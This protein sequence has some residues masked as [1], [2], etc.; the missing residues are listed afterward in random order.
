MENI[1][2]AIQSKFKDNRTKA[3]VNLI[4]TAGW[5]SAKQNAFFSEF[6][7]SP[8]Q[9]N[10]LRILR[11]ANEA[12][13]M[14][15]IKSRMIER[16]PNATRL[17]DKLCAKELLQRYPSE[18]DR[19]VVYAEISPQGQELLNNISKSPHQNWMKN[20]SEDE[21]ELLSQLLDKIRY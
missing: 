2:D 10:I 8:Q 15:T 21:A 20:I 18:Q 4:Y 17:V 1:S 19:R 9:Y 12:L 7:I 3:L 5:L 14:Q 6:G 11:G 13:T 16:A